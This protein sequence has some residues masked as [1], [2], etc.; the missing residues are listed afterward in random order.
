MPREIRLHLFLVRL[1][2]A[3][4]WAVSRCRR[5]PAFTLAAVAAAVIVAGM[6]VLA[7]HAPSGG[8]R[9]AAIAVPGERAH[10][11]CERT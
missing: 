10:L 6:A 4:W 5:S 3:P 2:L 9:W 7:V 11:V 8:C 1:R